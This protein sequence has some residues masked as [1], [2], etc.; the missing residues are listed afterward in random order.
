MKGVQVVS[1]P[2]GVP[3]ASGRMIHEGPVTAAA[4]GTFSVV[5]H[6]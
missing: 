2:S 6:F 4:E 1:S 3:A 5:T